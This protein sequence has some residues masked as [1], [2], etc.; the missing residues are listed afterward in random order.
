MSSVP[1]SVS[2]GNVITEIQMVQYEVDYM[3]DII[4]SMPEDGLM[5]EWGSGGSTCKWIETLSANQ[6]LISIEHNENWH[7][8][9]D[10]AT[11]N[12]FDDLEK[13]FRYYHISEQFIQHGYGSLT[14]EHPTGTDNYILPPPDDFWDADVFFIDGIARA[15]C[16]MMVLLKHTKPNPAIFIHD[17]LGRENWYS[18]ASQLCDVEMIG[19]EGSY[20][21]LARLH[22]K[23]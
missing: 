5:V 19:D 6:K 14:E 13:K 4:K 23:K 2:Y 9:V 3:V 10:R 17:Y 18:W 20:S 12:H 21:T 16:L 22:L 1:V 8:R 7:G 11:K 15:T